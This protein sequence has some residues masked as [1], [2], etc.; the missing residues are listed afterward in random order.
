MKRVLLPTLRRGDRVA[1]D[2]EAPHHDDRIED[3][4][5]PAR[6][7]V[8]SAAVFARP[9]PDR[10]CVLETEDVSSSRGGLEPSRASAKL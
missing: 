6:E 8:V 2:N 5:P 7:A 3:C 9:E 10:E 4:A 1:E